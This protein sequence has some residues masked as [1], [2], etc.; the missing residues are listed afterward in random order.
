[1]T[2]SYT[3]ASSATSTWLTQLGRQWL[4]HY[5]QACFSG[6]LTNKYFSFRK[7]LVFQPLMSHTLFFKQKPLVEFF[8]AGA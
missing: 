6:K 4:A 8:L 7:T 5:N 3:R 2:L 1:M